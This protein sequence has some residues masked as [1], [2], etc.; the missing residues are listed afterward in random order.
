MT[1]ASDRERVAAFIDALGGEVAHASVGERKLIGLGHG[2]PAYV[3]E[4]GSGIVGVLLVTPGTPPT[5]EVATM[6][7]RDDVA[8]R[9]LGMAA[10]A[11][12]AL[13]VWTLG[14][15]WGELLA[16]LGFEVERTLH[17]MEVSLPVERLPL[18]FTARGF[19]DGDTAAWLETN[20]LAFAGHPEQG[21][22]T[23]REFEERTARPWWDAR[24]LRMAWSGETLAGS[25]W[26]KVHPDGM[27]EIYVIGL[28]PEYRGR[29]WGTQLVLEGLRHL[30]EARGC[31][32]AML[33]VDAVNARAKATYER[34]GFTSTSV[35]RCYVR[36]GS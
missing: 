9:L 27:G 26:T 23:V 29:G 33:Y 18:S 35:D 1:T 12:P 22:W 36:G 2:S 25:C 31:R 11:H 14:D 5:C 15:R 7:G 17:R 16:G 30:H 13:R 19:G 3:V 34:I 21:G 32:R 10:T 4:E 20:N 8:A 6:A 28:R 24:D